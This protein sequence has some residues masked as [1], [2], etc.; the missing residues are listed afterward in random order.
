VFETSK[1]N[2]YKRK[3]G[4]DKVFTDLLNSD[5]YSKNVRLRDLIIDYE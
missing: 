3:S 5:R 4:A 1:D 2:Y